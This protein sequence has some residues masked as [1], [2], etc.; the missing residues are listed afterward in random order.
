MLLITKKKR[1]EP[2][3]Q[4][5]S[6]ALKVGQKLTFGL[7]VRSN[8]Q[9]SETA[10]VIINVIS[11]SIPVIILKSVVSAGVV[12]PKPNSDAEAYFVPAG[13]SVIVCAEVKPGKY[14][15]KSVSWD[16]IGS[17]RP[18]TYSVLEGKTCLTLGEGYLI[19]HGVYRIEVKACDN[20]K[21]CGNMTISLYATPHVSSCKVT[22]KQYTSCKWTT[23]KVSG[24]VISPDRLPLTYQVIM[25]SGSNYIPVTA[26]E[27]TDDLKFIGPPPP[28]N[29]DKVLLGLLVCDRFN[30]CK[31]FSGDPVQVTT[32]TNHEESLKT[33]VKSAKFVNDAGNSLKALC[34]FSCFSFNNNNNTQFTKEQ[35]DDIVMYTVNSVAEFPTVTQVSSQVS[36][37]HSCVL[38]LCNHKETA[39]KTKCLNAIA[40]STEKA[41]SLKAYLETSIITQS[42]DMV[43]SFLNSSDANTKLLQ[44][45][46]KAQVALLA[47]SA[48]FLPLGSKMQF[49][50]G[51]KGKPF[52]ILYHKYID[53]NPLQLRTNINTGSLLSSISF[54]KKVTEKFTNWDCGEEARCNGAVISMSLYPDK[55]PYTLEN[56]KQLSPVV[57]VSLLT[58]GN[59][60]EVKVEN[61]ENDIKIKL[62]LKTDK[63]KKDID[64][65][66]YYWDEKKE[67]WDSDSVKT[68][69][70]E[71]SIMQCWVSHLS[72]F[73]VLETNKGLSTASIAG[74]VVATLMAVFIICVVVLFFVRKKQSKEIRV[75][76]EVLNAEIEK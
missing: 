57:D 75:S 15:L 13:A 21:S 25:Y 17:T 73:V 14:K 69:G 68:I 29:E 1:K 3:L 33:I 59:G 40:K 20:M 44:A 67:K 47:H 24:C 23:A 65:Y 19:E 51:K 53:Q 62:A 43:T 38:P 64:F 5:H 6:N 16:I 9:N 12:I 54:G 58:P 4:F 72:S 10:N 50:S 61:V 28:S 34:L 49:G 8:D 71:S 2:I 22:F 63:M 39:Y 41:S 35:M 76:T 55:D 30:K 32:G 66:C 27:F 70:A 36:A 45:A 42:Y 56:D 26:H 31:N 18:F 60:K 48:A 52:S 37:L 74:I 11:G 46:K 7:K